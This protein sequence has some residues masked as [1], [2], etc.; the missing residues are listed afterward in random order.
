M[1][2]C[3]RGVC[4]IELKTAVLI[5]GVFNLV[6]ALFGVLGSGLGAAGTSVGLAA[7]N[8]AFGQNITDWNTI[9]KDPQNLSPENRQQLDGLR[10]LL[11][12]QQDSDVD[13]IDADAINAILVVALGFMVVLL[14]I[15]ILYVIVA[16]LL[17]H[18]AR[19]GKPGLLIPWVV[20]TAIT[21]IYDCAKIIQTIVNYWED[22]VYMGQVCGLIG[23]HMGI[24]SYLIVVVVFFWQQL[25]RGDFS[26][27]NE[28]RK[29]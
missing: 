7:V 22:P 14:I 26:A 18:G 27:S 6:A 3:N 15:C 19:K 16:S 1:A 10:N 28:M 29:M 9:F 11:G 17:I 24:A 4:C 13:G 12:L 23:C 20:L 8:G 21:F 25:R 5:I 2:G